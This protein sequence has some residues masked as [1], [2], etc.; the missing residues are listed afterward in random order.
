MQEVRLSENS[1]RH[2][3]EDHNDIHIQYRVTKSCKNFAI[4]LKSAEKVIGAVLPSPCMK[5][6]VM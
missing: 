3:L 6:D 4:F 1:R 2:T 5:H